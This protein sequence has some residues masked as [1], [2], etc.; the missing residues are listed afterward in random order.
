MFEQHIKINFF[1]APQVYIPYLSHSRAPADYNC[2]WSHN[3]RPHNRNS[4]K[5]NIMV[6]SGYL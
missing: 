1:T 4:K 2:Q 6:E 5:Q 3:P